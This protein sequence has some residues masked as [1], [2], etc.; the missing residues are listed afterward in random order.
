MDAT[1]A[2]PPCSL[3]VDELAERVRLLRTVQATVEA[4]LLQAGL[5]ADELSAQGTGPPARDALLGS[6]EV[7]GAT[8]RREARRTALAGRLS[9]LAHTMSSGRFGPDHLDALV[10]RLGHLDDEVLAAVELDQ[11]LSE[12]HRLPADTFDASLRRTVES[13]ESALRSAESPDDAEG[14]GEAVG[15][16]DDDRLR[17]DSSARHWFDPRTGMG[18]I[19]ATLDP[20]RYEAMANALDQ[21]TTALANNR[22]GSRQTK[23]ANLAAQA[24]YE[25][26]CSGGGRSPNLPHLVVVVD[27]ETLQA[28]PHEATICETADGKDLSLDAVARLGCDAVIRKVVLDHRGVPISVGRQS[29]TATAGQRAAIQSVYSSCAWGACDRPLSHCQLHHIEEWSHGGATDLP[30]LVPLCSF[31]H[32]QV[33]EGRWRIELQADRALRILRP[34]GSHHATTGTPTRRPPPLE[35]HRSLTTE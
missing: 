32:H 33:H 13:A 5:R 20:E 17:A 11:L 3:D 29:R 28:G 2:S 19:S 35:R 31:H 9:R 12:G 21:A 6:G 18:H 15:A 26:I 34:D 7:R 16:P 10:R 30:N 25:L 14:V 24:L 27:H 8:A 22:D 4:S 23:N 1:S